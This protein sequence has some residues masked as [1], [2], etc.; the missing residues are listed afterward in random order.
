MVATYLDHGHVVRHE[1]FSLPSFPVLPYRVVRGKGLELSDQFY[2]EMAQ[3]PQPV[4]KVLL[5]MQVGLMLQALLAE[6]VLPASQIHL[7]LTPGN[8]LPKGA[9]LSVWRAPNH[10]WESRLHAKWRGN[11]ALPPDGYRATFHLPFHH[12]DAILHGYITVSGREAAERVSIALSDAWVHS[13]LSAM[14]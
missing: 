4:A 5:E 10:D 9:M 11:S 6:Y 2:L 8:L 1:G 13:T 3:Q 7:V 12:D 14:V